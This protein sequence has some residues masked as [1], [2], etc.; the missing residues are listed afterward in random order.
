MG[1]YKTDVIMKT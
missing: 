1:P